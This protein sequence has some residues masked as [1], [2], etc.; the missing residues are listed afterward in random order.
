VISRTSESSTIPMGSWDL[1]RNS[2][3]NHSS[4]LVGSIDSIGRCSHTRYGFLR[5]LLLARVGNF[6]EAL[7]K[8]LF[9]SRGPACWCRSRR[10]ARSAELLKGGS[11]AETPVAEPS[12]VMGAE[13]E[14]EATPRE[15]GAAVAV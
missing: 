11:A 12:V 7:R 5:L 2:S 4:T 1:T 14:E 15:E 8:C 13:V 3:F 6:K 9:Q 10:S